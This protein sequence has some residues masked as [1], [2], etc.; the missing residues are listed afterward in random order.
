MR[1]GKV[2]R[3][4]RRAFNKYRK[5]LLAAFAVDSDLSDGGTL[6]AF[7]YGKSDLTAPDGREAMNL[8]PLLAGGLSLEECLPALTVAVLQ[9]ITLQTVIVA[10][11]DDHHIEGLF[12]FE[13]DAPPGFLHL[14]VCVPT[15][16]EV[17]VVSEVEDGIVVAP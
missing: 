10:V 2:I 9:T 14:A 15:A 4:G 12:P 5:W 11:G 3:V 17:V 8:D 6:T 13:A 1:V 16:V 7:H